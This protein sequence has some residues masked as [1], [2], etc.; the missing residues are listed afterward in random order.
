MV[1]KRTKEQRGYDDVCRYRPTVRMELNR[2]QY[3]RQIYGHDS[4]DCIVGKDANVWWRGGIKCAVESS[5]WNKSKSRPCLGFVIKRSGRP[6][7]TRPGEP[8]GNGT[9]QMHPG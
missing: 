4:T 6:R 9:D 3:E 8:S 1:M 7:E 5:R 2:I